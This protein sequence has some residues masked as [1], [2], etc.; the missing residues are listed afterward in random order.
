MTR[1]RCGMP[2]PRRGSQRGICE[3]PFPRHQTKS[4]PIWRRWRRMCGRRWPSWTKIRPI[5]PHI[6]SRLFAGR[7]WHTSARRS[8]IL[9]SM[10]RQRL[11]C[12]TRW[13]H[14]AML[15]PRRKT[16]MNPPTTAGRR[17]IRSGDWEPPSSSRGGQT[18]GGSWPA[19]PRRARKRSPASAQPSNASATV[20]AYGGNMRFAQRA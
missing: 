11:F 13:Q 12:G 1:R 20:A 17:Q 2:G 5:S 9:E 18:R 19:K 15:P 8:S 4:Q 7:I 6:I 16:R 14:S 3:W 10:P